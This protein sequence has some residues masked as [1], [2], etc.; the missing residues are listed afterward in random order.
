MSKKEELKTAATKLAESQTPEVSVFLNA[1]VEVI[2][3]QSEQI[4]AIKKATCRPYIT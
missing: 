3:E 4:A 2:N 1:L